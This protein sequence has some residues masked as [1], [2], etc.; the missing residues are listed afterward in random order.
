MA[1]TE[2]IVFRA[3]AYPGRTYATREEAEC[4][5]RFWRAKDRIL[6]EML[7]LAPQRLLAPQKQRELREAIMR[8]RERGERGDIEFAGRVALLADAIYDALT[9]LPDY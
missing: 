3:D 2:A 9:R 6:R 8:P 1:I 7:G 5:E 4:A